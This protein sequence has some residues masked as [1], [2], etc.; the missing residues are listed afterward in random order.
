MVSKLPQDGEPNYLKPLGK[1][2][3]MAKKRVGSRIF[4]GTVCGLL[5]ACGTPSVETPEVPLAQPQPAM[6]MRVQVLHGRPSAPTMSVV[7]PQ[8][9][10]VASSVD[11]VAWATLRGLKEGHKLSDSAIA[12]AKL[13]EIHDAGNGPLLAR[14]EQEV[15]GLPVFL[16]S[17]NIA[18]DRN[19]QPKL[20][21][22]RLATQLRKVSDRFQLDESV[23]VESALRV[24]SGNRGSAQS[25]SAAVAAPGGYSKRQLVAQLSDSG[26]KATVSS[27]SR[28]VYF[29]TDNGLLPGYYIELD[30]APEDSTNSYA[31]SFVVSAVDGKIL[32][33][34]NLSE[35][36][37]YT[38]RVYADGAP[39][40]VPWDGAQGNAYSPY[41]KAAP[42]G[43]A[44]TF[45]PGTLVTLENVPFR[46]NDPWLPEGATELSGN[47]GWAYVDQTAPD[48]YTAGD[49]LVKPTAGTTFDR[50]FDPSTTKPSANDTAKLT[51]ATNLFYVINYLHDTYYDAGW[52]E[53]AQNPQKVNYGRGGVEGDAIRLEAQDNGGRNNAN[54]STPAD[55]G[56]P[57]IQM[58]LW[59]AS[60][61]GLTVN[62]PAGL[63]GKLD[64][65]GASFGAT[66]YNLTNTVVP[67]ADAPGAG[68]S[69]TDG[70]DAVTNAAAVAGKIALIDRGT[71]S[72][73]IKSKN[74]QNAGAVGVIIANNAAGAGPPGIGGTDA[75]ITIPTQGIS[76]EDGAKIRAAAAGSVSV[77]MTRT[78]VERDGSLDGTIVSHEWGHIL[79]NRLIG[80]G[81]GLS[82][83]QG[84]SMGEGWSDFVAMLMIVRPEDSSVSTNTTWNGAYPTG[85]PSVFAQ[86]TNAFYEGIRRYPYS[87]DL[88]KN[89]LTFKH[90]ENGVPLPATPKPAF[91]A[92]GVDNA[93]VHN[94]G[95]VWT[96]ALW[97]CY[98]ALLKDS[99]R[100]TFQ[101][102]QERMRRY[103][104]SGMKLTPSAPTFLE[105]RDALLFAIFSSDRKDYDL[106]VDG[107]AKR[108]MGAGAVAPDSASMD[109][110][111]V[112]EDFKTGAAL[113]ID[114][115]ALDQS[116]VYCDSD[117]IL[118]NG[119]TGLFSVTVRNGGSKVLQNGTLTVSTP[120]GSALKVE[121]SS[122]KTINLP[123]LEPF[124][125][126]VI[127]VQVSMAGATGIVPY[128][129]DVEAK[130]DNL[131]QTDP[132]Q[133]SHIDVGNYDLKA[134]STNTEKFSGRPSNW[135]VSDDPN[136][137]T[138]EPWQHIM[139]PSVGYFYGPD[140]ASPSDH[141]LTSPSID[142]GTGNFSVSFKHRHS[143][144]TDTSVTPP[145]YYDGGVVEYSLDGKT[146]TDVKD[147]VGV[148][149]T[150]GYGGT[151]YAMG[152][153]PLKGRQSFVSA[154]QGFA[155]GS[156]VT[157]SFNFGTALAGK[158][159][160]L[161]FRLGT[162]DFSGDYGWDID[163]VTVAG[164]S[165]T[166]FQS[167]VV[168]S[169]TAVCKAKPMFTI[170]LADLK[171]IPVGF[172]VRLD[173]LVA[174]APG[175]LSWTWTQVDGTPVQLGAADT[176]NVT[177]KAPSEP[178]VIHLKYVA[179]VGAETREG[180]VAIEVVKAGDSSME[181]TA[182]G[183]QV[184]G[185]TTPTLWS[186]LLTSALLLLGRRRRKS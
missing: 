37:A 35:D 63:A 73:V 90:I 40:Y 103:L 18:M 127:Q 74:A 82:N 64:A 173:P 124:E 160:N 71:C 157:S 176:A 38:Y 169:A 10:V 22:G 34:K 32:F 121:G 50:S 183:C 39:G 19:M 69:T 12:S 167:Q 16:R 4:L 25:M 96:A 119:E 45:Q 58:Y 102:A 165:S 20:A 111:G 135:K 156:W 42:D 162:D 113:F 118:D 78:S 170:T 186:G 54:A 136:L 75:T 120:A 185:S 161:R 89:P 92:S 23:A 109:H 145:D 129:L 164:A 83:I 77:T 88:A 144:E 3:M 171:S 178:T 79:S 174:N 139:S 46:R 94:S 59:D 1:E 125:A 148:T 84:R 132:V 147:V 179:R 91:G 15:D 43:S 115:M 159:V 76:L 55:G 8:Q 158:K 181:G 31:R 122:T 149:I 106:C 14:F 128:Q 151:L 182:T 7:A 153:N 140:T 13:R 177:F 154:S 57:R 112:T 133:S 150:G 116:L 130:G 105:A 138:G 172:D 152:S 114:K 87:T 146:W 93:E 70:C 11:E 86:G 17:V 107:F 180:T 65:G 166:P 41:P 62:A 68:G 44:P 67:L 81:A 29:P 56:M 28:R 61:L 100:L 2:Q 30:V 95:E 6:P 47:N 98:A 21:S 85:A 80:N 66:T 142:V 99:N 117:G 101:Q 5:G 27:R 52:T 26:A 163:E 72:F 126:K 184:G 168:H 123:A 49:L 36:A 175:T 137:T 131:A 9:P 53:S 143:F 97:E 51:V 155:T 60:F 110:A 141:Y 24:M 33:E 48:G 108:G 134:A 104:V